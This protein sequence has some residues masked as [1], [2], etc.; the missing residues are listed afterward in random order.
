MK[1]QQWKH[2]VEEKRRRKCKMMK[3]EIVKDWWI[4]I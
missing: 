2:I 1:G 3:W 4:F